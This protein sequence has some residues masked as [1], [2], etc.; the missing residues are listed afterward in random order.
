M[1]GSEGPSKRKS[2]RIRAAGHHGARARQGEQLPADLELGALAVAGS[3]AGSTSGVAVAV[4]SREG[5][6]GAVR[7]N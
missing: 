7:T 3:A 6:L 4:E 2:G 5:S 1:G